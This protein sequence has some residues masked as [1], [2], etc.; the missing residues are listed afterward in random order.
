MENPYENSGQSP[1]SYRDLAVQAGVYLA[2]VL[3]LLALVTYLTGLTE[4]I[5]E[6][7]ALRW[8]NNLLSF[9]ISFYFIRAACLEYRN[10]HLGG[11][12]KTR[13]CVGIGTLAGLAAGV[14]V[15]IWTVVFVKFI[16]PD[17]ITKI[18]DATSQA[19]ADQGMSEEQVEQQMSYSKPF[20][21]PAVFFVSSLLSTVFS[22]A[23]TGLLAGVLLKRAPAQI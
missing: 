15:G 3:I 14:I 10:L 5:M 6:S 9:G 1:T 23:L 13:T 12:I 7:S 19:M 21:T 16:D 11:F 8:A 2:G 17:F 22:G 4:S 20:F 18:M